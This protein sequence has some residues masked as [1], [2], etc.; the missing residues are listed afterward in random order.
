MKGVLDRPWLLLSLRLFALMGG[1]A[2][3]AADAANP[4]KSD[5]LANGLYAEVTTP[6]GTFTCELY[7]AKAPLTVASFV[8]LAEGKLGPAPRK[9]FF[10]GVK[11][12]RVV[13]DFVVQGGDPTGTGDGGPGYSFPDE[14][15]AGLR[16]DAA[17][18][19][20]MANDGPDTNGSQFFLT[21][22]ETN[23]LNYLHSV[24]GRVVRGLDVLSKIQPGD[25]MAIRILRVGEAA[26][27]FRADEAALATLTAKAKK[28]SGA[29][30]PGAAAHFHDPDKLLPSEPP[31][32]KNFNFKLANLERATGL[33][34]VARLFAKSPSAA[35]DAQPGAYMRALAAKLG[36]AQR[37]VLVSYFADDTDWRVWIGDELTPRFVGQPGTAKAF[38]E[39][40]VM[41][42]VKEGFLKA[43]IAAGDADYVR[44]QRTSPPDNQP[45]PAQKLKLQTDALLDRL[46]LKLE[47][48]L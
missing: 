21:L 5:A 6:R 10:E 7:F 41:H 27:A 18:V 15:V 44:Q 3:M 8:G 33:R 1:T 2:G 38:T 23:R 34:I 28:Y 48:N 12:H 31:R 47:P 30:E 14:F 40:G 32:A 19:L 11:F 35:E 22:H 17:G 9:P 46:I 43:A 20:S 36:V 37:G 13:P 45:P 29:V 24:F 16:H 42:E 4:K 26:K 39:S 25:A